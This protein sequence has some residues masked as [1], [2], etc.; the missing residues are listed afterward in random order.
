MKKI[1]HMAIS[2]DGFIA[3]PNGD[4]NWVSK[5]DS[6]LFEK[7]CKE[8]GCIIVG[9][10]TFDQFQGEL[11]PMDG[12]PNIVLSSMSH[13]DIKHDNVFYVNSPERAIEMAGEMSH[14]PVLIAGGG[15]T[16]GAFLQSGLIDEIFLSVHP[17]LINKGIKLFEGI[18]VSP[19]F[20]LIDTK[21]LDDGLVELH[22]AVAK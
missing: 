4:S 22:Y 7:R 11:Y 21:A 8:A 1:L 17:L 19:K 6:A 20:T 12:I 9:R 2:M 14:G 3:K 10:K 16:N 5:V 15:Q 13:P 18:D